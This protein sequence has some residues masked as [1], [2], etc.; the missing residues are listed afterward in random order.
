MLIRFIISRVSASG[1][2]FRFTFRS[3]SEVSY[4]DECRA[5]DSAFQ[6]AYNILLGCSFSVCLQHCAAFSCCSE[7]LI[8]C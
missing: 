5:S 8:L 3:L 1:Y 6:Y 7:I 2:I 4:S